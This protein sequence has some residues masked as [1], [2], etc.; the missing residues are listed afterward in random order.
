MAATSSVAAG[1]GVAAATV[2]SSTSTSTD[3]AGVAV[4][5]MPVPPADPASSAARCRLGIRPWGRKIMM[6]TSAKP[7]IQIGSEPMR[8]RFASRSVTAAEHPAPITVR[9]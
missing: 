5:P 6:T 1:S 8:P 7:N 3:S 4:A 9:T 2:S